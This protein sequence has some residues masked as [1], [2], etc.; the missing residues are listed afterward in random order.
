MEKKNKIWRVPTPSLASTRPLS[1]LCVQLPVWMLPPPLDG[2]TNHSKRKGKLLSCEV[3][4]AGMRGG[5][6][7]AC[8]FAPR[9][10]R[11]ASV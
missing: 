3:T 10:A 9:G 4:H 7:G 8:G 5:C 11:L 6:A 1:P 2:W